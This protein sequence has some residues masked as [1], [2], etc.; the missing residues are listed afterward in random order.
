MPITTVHQDPDALTLTVVGEF[1]VSRQRLWEAWLDPRQLERFWGP[2]TWPATFTRHEVFPGGRSDYF[3]TGPDGSTAAGF[4]E[5]LAVDPGR[6]FEV[7]DGFADADG[8][9]DATLPRTRMIITFAETDSGATFT[10]VSH[11]ASL[12]ELEQLVGMGMVE[13]MTEALGQMD[14]VVTD[15]AA[16]AA[17][18]ATSAQV[19]SD[20]KVRIT[21]VIRG[22]VAEVWR[23]HHDPDLVRRWMLGPDGW[24]MTVCEVTD[25]VG[26]SYRY[27]WENEDGAPG[28]GFTGELISST[29][30]HHEITTE[31]MIGMAGEPT[32]NELTLQAVDGGTLLSLV[33][34][35][36]NA[37][38]RDTVL[39]T[40]M[41]DG[42]ETSYQRLE[43]EVLTAA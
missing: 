27:E 9:A 38:V 25:T 41:T 21:R 12:A 34:T 35:Y 6:S 36:P 16:F 29:P 14:Q 40:G 20:T 30:P 24:R 23:A 42:M 8:T 33:V 26:E 28:F 32:R 5:F 10:A 18:A 22:S 2:P 13:G 19:L 4:W 31:A 1:P 17:E 15:L 3:M 7:L 43:R 39:A 11:F 37:E